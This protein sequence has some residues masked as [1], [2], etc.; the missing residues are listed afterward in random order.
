MDANLFDQDK[1]EYNSTHNKPNDRCE[2]DDLLTDAHVLDAPRYAII[3]LWTVNPH[4]TVTSPLPNF[5]PR[6]QNQQK[7][8]AVLEDQI[9]PQLWVTRDGLTRFF[10]PST[11]LS[12][13]NKPKVIYSPM[14]FRELKFDGRIDTGALSDATPE[15]KLRKSRILPPRTI[16]NES[17]PPEFQLMPANGQLEAP[18]ATVELHFDVSN[19]TFK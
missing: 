15:A 10:A 19:I 1:L 2:S 14:D 7:Q 17:P 13:E 9:L 11:N 6:P 18:I 12:L 16:L 4:L 3:D 8:L 5:Q